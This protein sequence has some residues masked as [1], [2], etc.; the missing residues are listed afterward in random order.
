MLETLAKVQPLQA[1]ILNSGRSCH[2][3]GSV[4][5]QFFWNKGTHI[6]FDLTV[7][8][9]SEIVKQFDF[10]ANMTQRELDAELACLEA[11]VERIEKDA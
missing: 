10:S 8:E 2:V 4:C 11:Y 3:D 5:K 6:N 1:E 7:F 9:E